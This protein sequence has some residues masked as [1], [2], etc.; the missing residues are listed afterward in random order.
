MILTQNCILP[1]F[2]YV[3]FLCINVLFMYFTELYITWCA[4]HQVIK[5]IPYIFPLF[6]VFYGLN[7]F[8]VVPFV[9]CAPFCMRSR[10]DEIIF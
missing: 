8:S 5:H 7:E 2:I 9:L 1:E 3:F 6:C 4:V 10:R